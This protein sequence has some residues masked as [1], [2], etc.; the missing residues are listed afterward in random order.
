MWFLKYSHCN[1]VKV[2]WLTY[3]INYSVNNIN[4]V[5][6]ITDQMTT[7]SLHNFHTKL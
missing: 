4:I 3:S 1:K 5:L 6:A 7:N 2:K